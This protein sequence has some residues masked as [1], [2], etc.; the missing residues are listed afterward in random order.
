MA[1]PRE[2]EITALSTRS[3][4]L[5]LSSAAASGIADSQMSTTSP[6]T[7][8][9]GAHR[10]EPGEPAAE[11]LPAPYIDLLLLGKTGM[12]KSTTG[13]KLLAA[14]PYKVNYIGKQQA[15]KEE[16]VIKESK[17]KEAV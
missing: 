12:G 9:N 4:S 6:S 14:D 5:A 16:E 13:D 8:P 10:S 2:A 11:P 1:D 17:R 3:A 15:L 7:T